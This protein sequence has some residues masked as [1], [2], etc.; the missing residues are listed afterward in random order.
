MIYYS[1]DFYNFY[2]SAGYTQLEDIMFSL[3][4]NVCPIVR[5]S[6]CPIGILVLF[7]T[8]TEQNSMKYVG[9]N[10]YHQQMN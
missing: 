9:S 7:H 4:S 10:H 5:M 1:Y 8:N 3:C 2:I 6:R